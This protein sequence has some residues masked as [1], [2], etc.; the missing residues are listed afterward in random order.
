MPTRAQVLNELKSRF[1]LNF[2]LDQE[3]KTLDPEFWARMTAADENILGLTQ[4]VDRTDGSCSTVVFRPQDA[5]SLLDQA[6]SILDRAIADRNAWQSLMAQWANLRLDLF[7][8]ISLERI[9]EAEEGKF[10]FDFEADLAVGQKDAS[11]RKASALAT[12]QTHLQNLIQ[13]LDTSQ[14]AASEV[15]RRGAIA[16][17]TDMADQHFQSDHVDT[18]VPPPDLGP[19]LFNADPHNGSLP[20]ARYKMAKDQ[21]T[22]ELDRQHFG[23]NAD[24]AAVTA[25]TEELDANKKGLN[26]Q[27]LWKD[28]NRQFLRQR[29]WVARQALLTKLSM[30]H[31]DDALNFKA[32]AL[33]AKT[34]YDQAVSDAYQRLKAVDAGLSYYYGYPYPDTRP[35]PLP[36]LAP[37]G[38]SHAH[39]QII[40]WTRRVAHWLAAF[41][42]RTNSYIVPLS[43]KTLAGD[44]WS[45]LLKTG[46]VTFD[47]ENYFDDF[48]RHIRVRGVAAWTISER[49]M[50]WDVNERNMFWEVDLI[51]PEQAVVHF[52]S[53]STSTVPQGKTL[54]RLSR[55]MSRQRLSVPEVGAVTSAFT[56]S[57]AGKWTVFVRSAA[58]RHAPPANLPDDIEIDLYLSYLFAP[59]YVP[60]TASIRR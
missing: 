30:S 19:I 23:A 41:T 26:T 8:S 16:Y 37:P 1:E 11:D 12:Q 4:G 36:V 48:Q 2:D 43:L 45:N 7:Q 34:R 17:I 9:S 49:N 14:A 35:D 42:R 3:L 39:D 18:A 38:D 21:A 58:N 52:E 24:S 56:G 55:V 33:S 31:R 22:A 10:R 51:P 54:C 28:A 46:S 57:P 27:S 5:E 13:R 53:D 32:Q 20:R 44:S 50:L 60:P 29:A 40:A 25:Q 47:L 15:N 6:S 59:P